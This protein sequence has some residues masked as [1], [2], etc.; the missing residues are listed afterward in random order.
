MNTDH[1]KKIL[2]SFIFLILSLSA[3]VISAAFMTSNIRLHI[4]KMASTKDMRC[5]YAFLHRVTNST[6]RGS[7]KAIFDF[8]KYREDYNLGFVRG[9]IKSFEGSKITF[10]Y[11]RE[12]KNIYYANSTPWTAHEMHDIDKKIITNKKQ[13]ENSLYKPIPFLILSAFISFVSFRIFM[14]TDINP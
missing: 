5:D 4:K 12:S 1:R 10:C 7:G 9:T 3:F 14:S 11:D 2:I 8:G 6:G 13:I